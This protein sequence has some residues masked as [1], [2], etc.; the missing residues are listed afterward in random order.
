ML[1]GTSVPIEL[2]EKRMAVSLDCHGE[3]D[4]EELMDLLGHERSHT[5]RLVRKLETYPNG[6]VIW[7]RRDRGSGKRVF[8]VVPEMRN[9]VQSWAKA[10]SDY[11]VLLGRLEGQAKH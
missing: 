10:L 9:L 11:A 3:L 7:E 1:R 4:L 2:S 8:Y 6:P 5:Y